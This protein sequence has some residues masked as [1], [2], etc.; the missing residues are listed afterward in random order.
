MTHL[1][2][3][4]KAQG[5]LPDVGQQTCRNHGKGRLSGPPSLS[6]SAGPAGKHAGEGPFPAPPGRVGRPAACEGGRQR[7]LRRPTL[8]G[9]EGLAL[10][11][12]WPHSSGSRDPS[13]QTHDQGQEHRLRCQTGLSSTRIRWVTWNKALAHQSLHGDIPVVR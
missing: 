13:L 10:P 3:L 11:D 2:G 9:A 7:L 8:P 1:Q 5:L 4:Q 12:P 6:L